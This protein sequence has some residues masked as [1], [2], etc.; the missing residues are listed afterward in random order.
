MQTR[1]GKVEF[2]AVL[3]ILMALIL[4]AS[5]HP[6]QAA[7]VS[8]NAF[9]EGFTDNIAIG[10]T[11]RLVIEINNQEASSIRVTRLVCLQQGNSLSASSIS[12]LPGIIAANSVFKTEQYYRASAPGTATVHCELTA[13]N[14]ASGAQ[15]NVV[16]YNSFATVSPE[17]RLYFNAYSATR[18]A[19][20]GQAVFFNAIFGNRGQTT[21]TNLN[22]SCPELGRSLVYISSTPLQSSIPPGQSGFVQYQLKAV[23]P[24]AAPILCSLTATDSSTGSQVT[25]SAPVINIEVR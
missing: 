14:I 8:L 24:G 13:I 2:R 11:L 1:S 16:G 21:F 7:G 22:I 25:L 18:V 3:V 9:F 20:V 10:R 15:I 12:Q 19:T 6:A 5:S 4:A 17:T 23:R